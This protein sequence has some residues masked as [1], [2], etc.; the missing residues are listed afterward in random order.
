MLVPVPVPVPVLPA[1]VHF[2]P[3]G[4]VRGPRVLAGALVP[5]ALVQ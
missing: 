1:P 3:P 5:A 4:I 2:A